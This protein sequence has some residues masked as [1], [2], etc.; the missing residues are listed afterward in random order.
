MPQIQ[1]ALAAVLGTELDVLLP[2]QVVHA[3]L[4]VGRG[5]Q[6]VALVVAHVDGVGVL[7]VVQGVGDVGAVRVALFEGHRHFGAGEQRQV[8]T[9]GVA[10]VGPGQA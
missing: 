7:V 5:A 9:K 6:H 10:G 8:Q 1:L 2:A 4:V 3:Q